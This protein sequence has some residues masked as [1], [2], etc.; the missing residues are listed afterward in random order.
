VPDQSCIRFYISD[1]IL[2]LAH[3]W[4][5]GALVT[6]VFTPNSCLTGLEQQ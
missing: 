1:G 4:W 2:A 6:F 5:F 3:C